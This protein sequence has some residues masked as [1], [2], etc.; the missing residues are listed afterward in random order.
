VYLLI[1]VIILVFFPFL[2]FLINKKITLGIWS[3]KVFSS[4]TLISQPP[5]EQNF[6]SQTITAADVNDVPA[7]FVADPFII[8]HDSKLFMFF[9]ILDKSTGKGIIGLAV[10]QD[11]IK[12]D[13][14][15]C[16]LREEYHL[17]YP[18]VFKFNNNFYMIPESSEANGVFLYKAKSFPY[19]WERV[20]ELINGKYVDSSIFQYD[21]KWWIFAGR[22]G[23]L[24]LF[25][26]EQLE[27]DWIEHPKS[28]LIVNNYSIT[29]PGGRVI[30]DKGNIYRYTQDCKPNYGSAVRAFKIKKLSNMEFEEEEVNLVLSGTNRE[31][32]WR[33]DGMHTI[34]QLKVDH[35]QW[36][37]VVDGHKLER[38]NYVKWKLDMIYS[39]YFYKPK[40]TS[41]I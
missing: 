32:D 20:K 33:K 1:A 15:K 3:I 16:V 4:N 9:E 38:K 5:D 26:S 2:G 28:P 22:S 29:R 12:W 23:K 8:S 36:L 19:E 14:D 7:E 25:F 18:Y 10:S 27:G 6:L 21:N 24:H 35:N 40:N 11:G 30:V 39:K 41:T 37:I 13:Y 34:D 17:S 31:M